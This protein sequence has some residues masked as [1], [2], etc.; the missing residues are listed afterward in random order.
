MDRTEADLDAVAS[1][2]CMCRQRAQP[3]ICDARIFTSSIRLSSRPLVGMLVL[4]SSHDFIGA[5]AAAN[6]FSRGVMIISFVRGH[7]LKT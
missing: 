6:G 7:S 5:G 4:Q 3:L 2:V 1:A